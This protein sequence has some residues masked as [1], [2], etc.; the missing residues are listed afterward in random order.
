[1]KKCASAAALG[2]VVLGII[3]TANCGPGRTSPPAAQA[4]APAHVEASRPMA[5]SQPWQFAVLSDI[6]IN[7]SG[8]VAPAFKRMVSELVLL[9]PR[10][11]IIAG[12]STNGNAGDHHPIERVRL[13]WKALHRTLVPLRQAGIPIFAIEGNHD[14]YEPAHQR[15]YAEAWSSLIKDVRPIGVSGPA[16]QNYAFDLD[17][18]HFT[19]L[20]VVDQALEEPVRTWLAGDLTSPAATG[21]R[22]RFAFGHVPLRSA[23]GHSNPR[24]ERALGAELLKGRVNAYIAGH[25]HLFW[26]ETLK[27]GGYP[28]RQ[29]TV[30][31][32]SGTY[33][34]PLHPKL[35]AEHCQGTK[36]L[37]PASR[38][39]FALD[40]GTRQQ[41]SKVTLLMVTINPDGY[42]TR[43]M[44]LDEAGKLGPV[45][46]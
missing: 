43:F 12:D 44:A 6:H 1:M 11:V 18:V 5:P 31:T 26:D 42:G 37:L 38:Q 46:D 22:L 36:C 14:S 16:P 35:Y 8:K 30:G 39:T 15:G 29:I 17:G 23:M 25:E 19:M 10:L 33:T 34:Y 28:L 7:P 2:L 20:H 13:W 24:F 3:G 4:D 21:A 27:I 9:K 45:A 40:P 41:K 32:A